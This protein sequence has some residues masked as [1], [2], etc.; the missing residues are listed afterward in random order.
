M[1]LSTCFS[2][3]QVHVHLVLKLELRFPGFWFSSLSLAFKSIGTVLHSK[4][5]LST[6]Q[7]GIEV[8]RV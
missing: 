3:F 2:L 1:P 6:Y 5:L 7:P 8:Y 4:Q